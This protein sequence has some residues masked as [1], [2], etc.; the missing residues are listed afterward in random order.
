MEK[1]EIEKVLDELAQKYQASV[2]PHPD[3]FDVAKLKIETL[4]EVKKELGI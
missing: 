4:Q 2:G 1:K 3:S